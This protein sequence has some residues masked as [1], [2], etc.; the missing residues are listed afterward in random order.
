MI[1]MIEK[2]L[3]FFFPFYHNRKTEE[4]H[5]GPMA[6]PLGRGKENFLSLNKISSY[7][8]MMAPGM[9]QY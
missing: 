4:T 7:R 6:L 8:K 9:V 2:I 3:K 5:L 1:I